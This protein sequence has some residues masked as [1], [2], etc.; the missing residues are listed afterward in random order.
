MDGQ[1]DG[2][3]DGQIDGL[4]D[5][6]MDRQTKGLPHEGRDRQTETGGDI[7]DRWLDIVVI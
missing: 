4:I 7:L 3:I 6:Q 2:S 1:T 5:K